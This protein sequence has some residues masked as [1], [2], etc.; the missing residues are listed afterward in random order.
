MMAVIPGI[1][2]TSRQSPDLMQ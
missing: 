2:D 1:I